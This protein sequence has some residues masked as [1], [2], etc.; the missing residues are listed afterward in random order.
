M[1][2]TT[3]YIIG[4][5]VGLIYGGLV[6]LLCSRLTA[7]YLKKQSSDPSVSLVGVMLMS[8][9]RLMIAAVA[10]L[11]AFLLRKV[12][13]WPYEGVLVGTAIGLSV[14]AAVT[15]YLLSKKYQDA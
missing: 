2:D 12:L 15:S 8:F 3:G 1:F 6:S 4:G 10:L 7:H 9:G 14:G 13:P 5:V 11:V